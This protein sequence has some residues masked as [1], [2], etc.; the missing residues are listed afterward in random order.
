MKEN[1]IIEFEFHILMGLPGS[2]KTYWAQH[3]YPTNYWCNHS[4]RMIVDLDKFKD[5]NDKMVFN[6]LNE[7]FKNYM[8]YCHYEKIDVCIDGPITTY[9]HLYIV[10]DDIIKYMGLKCQWK[11][12]GYGEYSLSFIIHQWNEDRNTCLYNDERRGRTI[13][14]MM[15]IK[16]FSYD[17]IDPIIVENHLREI[18]N[19][20]INKV[21]KIDH[22]IMKMTTYEQ[23]FEP[24][25]DNKHG[26]GNDEQGRY[27]YS[28]EWSL[29][30]EWGDC[31]GHH[32][33]V[34]GSESKDFIE[35]DDLLEKIAPQISFIQ[36][37][38]I[39][40]HCVEQIEW[41]VPDYYSSGTDE[42]C[43]RC[44]MRKLYEMLKEMN[45]I[46]D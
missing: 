40:N 46:E 20:N 24:A 10:I 22:I 41:H 37:K 19:L 26:H 44:D 34:S 15:S 6:A 12:E 32:G 17:Y 36:Y 30:G 3:N 8:D 4:G 25:C 35:L 21:E 45:Y 39:K 5:S 43:W 29:G 38:K 18:Y 9:D 2:G 16:N 11:K 42:A 7:E 23:I 1:K 27:L 28:E 14:S 33:H 13:K 31:W